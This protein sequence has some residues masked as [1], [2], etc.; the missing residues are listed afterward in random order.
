[1]LV[2]WA[3]PDVPRKLHDRIKR[4]DYLTR[5]IIIE[6]EKRLARSA[7]TPSPP[8]LQAYNSDFKFDLKQS[9][10]KDD[11]FDEIES[12]GGAGGGGQDE[13]VDF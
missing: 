6:Q 8:P 11:D 3:I 12:G 9:R 7:N 13:S 5:D 1:M 2:A 4:E 10:R